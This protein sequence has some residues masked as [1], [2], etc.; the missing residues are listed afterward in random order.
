M[1]VSEHIKPSVAK[2]FVEQRQLLQMEYEHERDEYKR[3]S[4][5]WGVE[6]TVQRGLCWYPLRVG[7]N[8]YD[9]LN[10]LVVDLYR[11]ES[12]LEQEH[13]FEYGRQVR[14]FVADNTM[15]VKYKSYTGTVCYVEPDRMVVAVAGTQAIT[16][17]ENC[18]PGTLGVQLSLD[19]TTYRTMF[20]ALN[21][22]SQ[23][24]SGRLAELRD[25]I[26]GQVEPSFR[27]IYPVR[28]PWLNRS[29]EVAV[30]NMLCSRD[31]MIVHG[32]PG[33]GKTTT[34]VEA[35]AETLNRE[36]QVLV[37]AQSNMAVD[38]ISQKLV[39]RGVR[40]LRI[41]NPTRVNDQML[42]YCYERQYEA[43]PDYPELWSI[44]KTIRQIQADG[45]KHSQ[46][47]SVQSRLNR[48][49]R[50]AEELEVKINVELFDNARVVAATL[51][52]S[53]SSLLTGRRFGT[54]FVDEAGQALEAA[55][56]IAVRKAD[57]VVLAGDHLQLPPTIKCYEAERG[58]LGRTM[59]EMVV[60]RWQ[61]AVTLLTTQYRM[62]R[63]IMQ[64]SSDW[65]Y[66]GGLKAADEVKMRGILDYDTPME[67]VDTSQF[68]FDEQVQGAGCS[69]V[70]VKEAEFFISQLEQYVMR[71]GQERIL[72][73]RIDFGLI[74]PYKAQVRYMRQL[75]K[76]SAVLRP[77]RHELTVDTIDGFQGQERD[78][79]FISLVRSNDNGQIGFLNDLRRMNVAITRAR[80][81]VVVIGNAETLRHHKFYAK[82]YD[83]IQQ[84]ARL[85]EQ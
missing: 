27:D 52:G 57:R 43:H 3:I 13:Q 59:M 30:N 61:Q 18:A 10:R 7:R 78:V 58:G 22:V 60:A 14:F 75:V 26:I 34:L 9:S 38:W 11:S 68:G 17:M 62:N 28:F 79:V 48:L 71:I 72:D 56:W 24:R 2:H 81:K 31:V 19:E 70:N 69:K 83:Y 35:I 64:F 85:V 66:G 37:C 77:L 82:L 49:R 44:R 53:N 55:T 51:V 36:P 6:R 23:A 67:W 8:R 47:S 39:E 65:F 20:E 84:L 80:M 50:R 63:H 1:A 16:D 25:V 12:Q 32:P 74:S 46:S 73:E 45:R 40:V 4:E 29:Q 42:G 33:T 54:L 41:G 15:S 5:Q 76:R 21:D